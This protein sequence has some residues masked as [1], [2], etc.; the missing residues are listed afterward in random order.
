MS[1]AVAS[2]PPRLRLLAVLVGAAC[3]LV[4]AGQ[5]S[6]QPAKPIV[7]VNAT[8]ATSIT[9]GWNAVRGA[10]RYRVARNGSVVATTTARSATVDGI[11]CGR[12]YTIAVRAVGPSG[13]LSAPALRVIRKGTGCE[14]RSRIVLTNAGFSCTRPLSTI[15]RNNGMNGN[16]GRLPLLVKINFTTYRAISIPAWSRSRRGCRGDGNS[17]TIDLIL[18]IEGDGRTQGG[19]VDAIKVRENPHDIQITG[20]ANCGPEG[21]GPDGRPDT[22]DDAHQDGAQIQGGNRV[23]FIDFT[24]G[25][26]AARRAT[27]Q[28]AAGTFVPGSVNNWPV[29][30]MACIRCK[31]VSCNHGMLISRSVGTVVVD[32]FWRSGNPAERQGIL[33]NGQTGLCNH[34]GGPCVIPRPASPEVARSSRNRCPTKYPVLG[35]TALPRVRRSLGP[36]VSSA[37]LRR[38][39]VLRRGGWAD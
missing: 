1:R 16:P 19:T 38:N 29:R 36:R 30:N 33:A 5:A 10:A 27:C 31:S 17:N 39:S 37:R 11:L 28:G 24:W 4:F 20:Y 2:S 34:S 14:P 9:I 23:E 21:L 26:W 25:D 15:A 8:T 35:L 3:A 13:G 12:R 18:E 32:S 7:R 22:R 6:A